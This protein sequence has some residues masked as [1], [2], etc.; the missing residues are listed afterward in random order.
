MNPK[1]SDFGMAKTC[2]GDQTEGN[3]YRV[4]GTYSYMA[5]EYSVDGLFSVKLDVFSFGMLLME[6][7][8]G[9]KNRRIYHSDH[10]VNLIGH[11]SAWG[12]WKGGNPLELVD[13]FLGESYSQSEV[14]RCIHISLLC[15]QQ[16]PEDR[17]TVTV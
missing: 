2:G 4:V 1:I 6:I 10:S 5:P 15:V 3:T 13:Q 7:V 17:P 12:L 11:L 9:T 8:S 16:T 14:A